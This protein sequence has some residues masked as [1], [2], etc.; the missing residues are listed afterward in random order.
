MKKFF[1]LIV[2][3]CICFT[4]CGSSAAG[5]ASGKIVIYTSMYRDVVDD[6]EI[7]LKKQFPNSG[8]EFSFGGTGTLQ[9]KLDEEIAEGQLGCDILLLADPS[10]SI[11]LKEKGMLHPFAYQEASSLAYDY[12]PEGYWYPVRISN[13]VLA[14][15]SAHNSRDNL[16]KTFYDFAHNAGL[17]GAVSMSNPLVSGTTLAA[18]A[19]LKDK[20]GYEYFEALGRQN[21]HIESG[22]VALSK[23]ETGERRLAMV[24][25]ES[26]LKLRE[27]EKSSLEI[28]YPTDGVV[29]IP[30]TVMIV[31][32]KWSANGNA[33]TAQ[34]I[35]SWFLSREGQGAIV[36]KW[37]H[38]VR[39]NFE[40]HPYD[41]I[42]S[43]TILERKLP[44]N[45]DDLLKQRDEI[46]QKFE[47]QVTH[48]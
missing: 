12:D 11:E 48:R 24:L 40:K 41:A 39:G 26:V 8:I 13:M 33:G 28:I 15:D 20:Y 42:S 10:Y 16:P 36:D 9:A 1:Y 32:D 35:A 7:A 27:E 46:Q 4:N 18:V 3:A 6:I 45:W 25:E 47:Q 14:F 5:K 37:M 31:N 34:E 21:V 43:G 29:V 23:L 30:S 22:A 17:R 44:V 2:L 38:S 19:A